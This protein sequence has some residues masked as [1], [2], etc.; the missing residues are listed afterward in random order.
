MRRRNA[1]IASL[2]A[3]AAVAVFLFGSADNRVPVGPQERP[4]LS[5]TAAAFAWSPGSGARYEID[6]TSAIMTGASSDAPVPPTLHL[7]GVL[8]VRVLSTDAGS[9]LTGLRLFPVSCALFG[10]VRPEM[11]DRFLY[12]RHHAPAGR[13]FAGVAVSACLFGG[14]LRLRAVLLAAPR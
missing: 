1:V 3:I 2:L 8:T 13:G 10:E 14:V 7:S 5:R 4:Q 12:H 11:R 9:V 6:I